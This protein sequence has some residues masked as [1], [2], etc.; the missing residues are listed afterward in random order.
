MPK[1]AKALGKGNNFNL[2]DLTTWLVW[3]NTQ[4]AIVRF[5]SS[6]FVFG[7]FFTR[8]G[9]LFVEFTTAHSH[10]CGPIMTI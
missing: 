10:T 6:S 9:F 4:F 7:Q 1:A 3:A 5:L 8:I 2:S